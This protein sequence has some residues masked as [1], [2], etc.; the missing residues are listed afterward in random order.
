[1]LN[2]LDKTFAKRANKLEHNHWQA[3]YV[4][5]VTLMDAAA[6]SSSHADTILTTTTNTA[7]KGNLKRII[8]FPKRNLVYFKIKIVGFENI[9]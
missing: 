1:M 9:D 7:T 8:I 6:A 4:Y 2:E 3:Y 5:R